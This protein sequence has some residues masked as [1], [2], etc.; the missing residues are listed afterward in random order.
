MMGSNYQQDVN[1]LNLFSDVAFYNNMINSPEH[2]EMTVDI[3]C[4]TALSQ[5]GV[6]HITIP[7]DIQEKRLSGKYT[8]HKVAGHTSDLLF[9]PNTVPTASSIQKAA[10]VLNDGKRIV[11]L[12]GQEH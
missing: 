12:A 1:L 11:I 8:K 2:A 9:Y 7:I 3:A 5:L 4:R 10:N 6:S